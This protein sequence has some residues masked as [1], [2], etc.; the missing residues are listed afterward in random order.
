MRLTVS[1]L[2]RILFS[3]GNETKPANPGDGG[4]GDGAV[5]GSRHR[6]CARGGAAGDGVCPQPRGEVYE[7]PPPHGF[8]F[9]GHADADDRKCEACAVGGLR[10]RKR[11]SQHL[12]AVSVPPSPSCCALNPLARLFQSQIANCKSKIEDSHATDRWQGF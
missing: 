6:G 4:G 11:G 3:D 9:T 12:L 5:R 1:A 7:Q 8:A 10:N 2:W